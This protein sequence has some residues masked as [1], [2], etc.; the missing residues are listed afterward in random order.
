L[1]IHGRSSAA[2][3]PKIPARPI[4]GLIGMKENAPIT[5]AIGFMPLISNV[6]YFFG[7]NIGAI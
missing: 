1:V 2:D 6:G 3:I 5:R 4:E 7:K